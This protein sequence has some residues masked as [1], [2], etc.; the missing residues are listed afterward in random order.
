MRD[1]LID[2]SGKKFG[3]LSVLKR[4][5]NNKWGH[6]CWLCKCDCGS[7]IKISGNSLKQK[8][9]QSCGC[10]NKELSAARR[11]KDITLIF[12]DDLNIVGIKLTKDHVAIINK[13]DLPLVKNYGWHSSL[14]YA[15][16]RIN[17]KLVPM[18]R[19]LL[20][21]SA[22]KEIDHIDN[23]KLNNRRGNLRIV[24]HAENTRNFLKRKNNTSGYTGVSLHKK[25]G[26]FLSYISHN[27]KRITIGYF[28]TQEDA[29]I[30]RDEQAKKLSVYYKLNIKD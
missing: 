12:Y 5:E 22:N 28:L 10:L 24:S 8:N 2:L 27:N 11:K 13:E 3:R 18:H 19:L 30:A 20:A 17:N 16:S 4:I 1:V 26:K 14:G 6:T 25:S 7:D 21:V 23:N 15:V 29:A 9:T